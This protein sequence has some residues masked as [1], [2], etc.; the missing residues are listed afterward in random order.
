[1]KK[2]QAGSEPDFT[3]VSGEELSEIAKYSE[4]LD[5]LQEILDTLKE[6]KDSSG[7]SFVSSALTGQGST[8]TSQMHT[9]KP[10]S[11]SNFHRLPGGSFN[12]GPSRQV[13]NSGQH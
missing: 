12:Q 1:M 13:T 5:L 7:S 9:H 11:P 10:S 4:N 2:D 3:Q 6:I 8:M